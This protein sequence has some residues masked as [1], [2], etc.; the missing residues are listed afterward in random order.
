MKRH[1]P[2]PVEGGSDSTMDRP[3]VRSAGL[4]AATL[5]GGALCVLVV[6]PLLAPILWATV[7][8][9]VVRPLHRRVERRMRHAWA[10]AALVVGVVALLVAVPFALVTAQLL[11][12][13]TEGI[14][15]LKSGEASLLWRDAL[16]RTRPLA[17]LVNW[18][19]RHVDLKSLVGQWTGE[20][21]SLLRRLLSGSIAG[22]AGW[23]I[24]LFI[25]FFLVRDHR[26]MLA[27]VERVLPLS[28]AETREV[29][30]VAADTVHAAV[31]GTMA[32]G[33]LQGT[34]GGLV[35]WWLDLPAPFVW[36]AVMA[37]LSVLP[38]LGAAL[39]WLPVS[40][41]LALNGRW[42]D[43][44]ALVAFG[45]IVI[46]L[47]DNLVYPLIVKGRLHLHAVPVFVSIIGGLVV[48]GA[49][50]VVLGPLLLAVT[51][52]LVSIWRRRL[53]IHEDGAERGAGGPVT[54]S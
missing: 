43:A 10:A 1:D 17:T 29:F 34:L 40:A 51:D 52:A 25:L 27:A 31:W 33:L 47:I 9:I 14:E 8:A 6:Y 35:F 54:R 15:F 12:E 38:V 36:G 30:K 20:T 48:F 5:L 41:Y 7:L 4:V 26:R 53:G 21:A 3:T 22:G 23:L 32:V 42:Q 11:R 45:A 13:A 28:R 49:S 19:E 24:M 44:L 18:V 37:V 46:G 16:A 39:V 50:G 2:A